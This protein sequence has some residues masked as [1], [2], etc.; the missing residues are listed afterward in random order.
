MKLQLKHL[1]NSRSPQ[2]W[3]GIAHQSLTQLAEHT[4]T[5]LESRRATTMETLTVGRCVGIAESTEQSFHGDR[6]QSS[7]STVITSAHCV[8]T[9]GV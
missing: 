8:A 7:V 2:N 9:A 3:S 1:A 5:C 6:Q 4:V